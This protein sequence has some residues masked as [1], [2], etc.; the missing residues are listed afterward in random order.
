MGMAGFFVPEGKVFG[1]LPK[2]GF[3]SQAQH[4]QSGANHAGKNRKMYG[5]ICEHA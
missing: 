2:W 3:P 5:N 1:D 4:V